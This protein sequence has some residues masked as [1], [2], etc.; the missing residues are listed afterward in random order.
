MSAIEFG[1]DI[2]RRA[3]PAR[4]LRNRRNRLRAVHPTTEP[5]LSYCRQFLRP[6]AIAI[7][8]GASSGSYTDLFSAHC[9]RVVA[10][11][12]NPD[13]VASLRSLR[14]PNLRVIAAAAG[15]ST[16]IATLR[17]PASGSTALG[18]IAPANPL[19]GEAVLA[20]DVPVTTIDD[21]MRS[22]AG[23]VCFLKIDVEGHEEEVLRG[24]TETLKSHRP[25]LQIEIEARHGGDKER[26][27]GFLARL[28]YRAYPA[29]VANPINFY[30][31][32]VTA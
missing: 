4:M 9:K 3:L 24:A 25:T 27:D 6:D 12:P 13:C 16:G 31:F 10:F 8:V 26:I 20:R 19:Q 18:T 5:E 29:A 32:V 30:Y 28:G 23:P 15:S 14:L 11:E 1:K 21:A 22:E 2:L 17:I 7:D